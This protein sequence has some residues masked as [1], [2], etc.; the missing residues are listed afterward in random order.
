VTRHA[1]VA[2][3]A[4]LPLPVLAGWTR[5]TLAAAGVDPAQTETVAE[6]LL[7]NDAAGRRNHGLE[8]LPVLL[9]RVADGLIRCPADTALERL[10]PSQARLDGGDGF[11]QHAGRLAIDA[12]M[13]LARETGLGVVGVRASNFYGTGAYFVARAAEAGFLSLALSNSFPKVAAAGGLRPVLGTNPLAFG[14]PRAAGR[15]LIVD[16]ST[17]GLAGSTVRAAE[18]AGTPLPEGLAIDAEGRPLTDPAAARKGTLLPAA[19]AKGFGLALMVEV[20]AGVLTGAG[21]ASGVGS[22]YAGGD[23]PANSGHF[24]LVLDPAR[25]M[26]AQEWA[27]R[28]EA[29]AEAVRASAP[30]GLV[31]LP[32]EARWEAL[33]RSEA[34]GLELDAGLVARLRE[35]SQAHGVA[36]PS[37]G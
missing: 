2:P 34:H 29:L 24:F 25:W 5:A 18:R 7:W 35:L 10:G 1:S 15:A 30:E 12:A 26:P 33:A 20:L 14:A 4:R 28:M 31:R 37:D 13:D 16:M 9:D 11:G 32:G 6:N 21:V 17:A 3:P 19:G 27:A 23:R 36:F 8:R 22:L